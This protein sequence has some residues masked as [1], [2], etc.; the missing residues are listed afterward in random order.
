C[1][2]ALA[3]ARNGVEA[4]A[5]ALREIEEAR[6]QVEARVAPLRERMGE[7]RLKEQAAQI[8]FDQFAAQLA[9]AGADEAR[10]AAEAEGA[11]RPS[12]LQGELTRLNQAIGELGAVNLAALE[13]LRESRERK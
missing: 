10:L 12:T 4:A 7:L 8:N 11:P 2:K 13:E 3:E 9:E 6:L 5:A 1:E